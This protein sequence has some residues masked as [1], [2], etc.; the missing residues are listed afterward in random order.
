MSGKN[1]MILKSVS[2]LKIRDYTLKALK[3]APLS[4]TARETFVDC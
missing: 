2:P 3:T 1:S 4:L